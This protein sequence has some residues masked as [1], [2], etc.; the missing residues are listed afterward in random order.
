MKPRFRHIPLALMVVGCSAW[1]PGPVFGDDVPALSGTVRFPVSRK[2]QASMGEIAVAATV[3]LIDSR[4]ADTISTAM[5]DPSGAFLLTFSGGFVP[6]TAAYYL[7]AVKGLGGN[8]VGNPAAR[9]R[10]LIRRQDGYW[11]S[12]TA[13]PTVLN[14]STTALSAITDLRRLDAAPL[15]GTVVAGNPDRFSESGTGISQEEYAT[16]LS[17]VT[18]SLTSDQDPL[19]NVSYNGGSFFAKNSDGPVI[20]LVLPNPAGVGAPVKLLGRNFGATQGANTV[21][22][23]GISAAVTPVDSTQMTITVP[24]GARSGLLTVVT[25]SGTASLNFTVLPGLAGTLAF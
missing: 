3:S 18:A 11:Q 22:V 8:R 13:G 1:T 2:V 6:G 4:S 12:I 25:G 19:A 9:V 17:L 7:E 20:S 5:T 14:R 16:V 10:T 15:I 21:T 24:P 23:G